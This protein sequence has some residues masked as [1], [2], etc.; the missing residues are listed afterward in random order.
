MNIRNTMRTTVV[1]LFL[2]PLALVSATSM[3]GQ[4][5]E[6]LQSPTSVIGDLYRVHNNGRGHLFDARGKVSLYKFCDKQLADLMW[7]DIH[8]TLKGDVGN[9]DFDPLYNAQDMKITQFQ[10]GSPVLEGDK[11]TVIVSFKNFGKLTKIKFRMV[12]RRQTWKIE[13]IDYGNDLNLIKT[14]SATN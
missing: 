5:A 3:P 12:H 14:L 4:T 9:L 8:D 1:S 10:F 7:K 2:L 6:I 13:N 11:A